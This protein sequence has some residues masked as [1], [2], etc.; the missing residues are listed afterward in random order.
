M[1][2]LQ[3]NE[4][5]QEFI[6]KY[7]HD[8]QVNQGSSL[9]IMHNE[10]LYFSLVKPKFWRKASEIANKVLIDFSGIG[11]AIE[12]G[13]TPIDCLK[14][15]IMEEIKLRYSELTFAFPKKTM[16][17]SNDSNIAKV[18]IQDQENN[19]NPI[20][21]LEF[22]L[23]LRSDRAIKGKSYSCLQL[24]VYLAKLKENRLLEVSEDEEIPAL[25]Y[26]KKDQLA[27]LLTG[28]IEIVNMAAPSGLEITWNKNFN[29][30][31]P[32]HIVLTPKFTPTGLIKGQ[33]DYAS[34]QKLIGD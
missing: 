28:N 19:P 29:I 26:V 17:I 2:V 23:P 10:G 6:E 9:I 14:R 7:S 13:E 12:K 3:T 18:E 20:Y 5:M 22:K 24:F 1:S 31:I 21:I 16:I 34:L 33:L 27:E 25:I 15:E 4:I 30:N 32:E 11:G 8:C